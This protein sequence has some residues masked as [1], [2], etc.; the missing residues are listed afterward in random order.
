MHAYWSLCVF[1]MCVGYSSVTQSLGPSLTKPEYEICLILMYTLDMYAYTYTYMRKYMYVH[2]H[3]YVY[4]QEYH[5]STLSLHNLIFPVS[6]K[7]L[8]YE[9]VYALAS[10]PNN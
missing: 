9:S 1:W 6:P 8:M 2:V 7:F 5:N 4:I 10:L 3:T